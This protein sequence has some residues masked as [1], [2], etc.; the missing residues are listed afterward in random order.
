[1]MS[2]WT[3][4]CQ[5]RSSKTHELDLAKGSSLPLPQSLEY[6]LPTVTTV[7]AIFKDTALKEHCVVETI[8]VECVI[9][10]SY[11]LYLKL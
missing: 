9:E 8:Y 7:E 6:V 1:M 10:L 11:S 3:C 2:Y 4:G 5:R